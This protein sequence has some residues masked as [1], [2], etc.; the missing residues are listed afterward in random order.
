MRFLDYLIATTLLTVA[1]AFCAGQ[2]GGAFKGAPPEYL[3]EAASIPDFWVSTVDGVNRFLDERI[4]KGSVERIGTSAGGRPIR[5]VF[6]GQPRQRK[7]TTTFSGALSA[8]DLRA[9]QIERGADFM[10]SAFGAGDDRSCDLSA[11]DEIGLDMKHPAK[12]AAI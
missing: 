8:G 2:G 12:P 9:F 10:D 4:H 3:A 7:G 6:Y 11:N 5:A 1:P